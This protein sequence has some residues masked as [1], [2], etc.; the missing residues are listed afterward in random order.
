MSREQF[1]KSGQFDRSSGFD[2]RIVQQAAAAGCK[3][4]LKMEFGGHR[5]AQLQN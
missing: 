3:N 1:E 5:G 2:Q 4:C